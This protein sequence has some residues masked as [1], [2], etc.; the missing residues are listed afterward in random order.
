MFAGWD[1][2]D[3]HVDVV[4]CG[5]VSAAYD[6][7]GLELEKGGGS[8]WVFVGVVDSVRVVSRL[9]IRRCRRGTL[10]FLVWSLAGEPCRWLG[11]AYPFV[12]FR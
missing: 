1:R 7:L 9:R 11:R 2:V 6:G 10:R 3:T 4:G 12:L 5:F 8:L